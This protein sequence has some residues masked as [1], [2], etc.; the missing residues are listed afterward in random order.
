MCSLLHT[1]ATPHAR[2]QLAPALPDF[3]DTYD[4]DYRRYLS[5]LA[6]V[7][8]RRDEAAALAAPAAGGPRG[9]GGGDK[10]AARAVL[11]GLGGLLTDIKHLGRY[12]NDHLNRDLRVR[13][14]L[15]AVP[16]PVFCVWGGGGLWRMFGKAVQGVGQGS[17]GLLGDLAA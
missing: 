8:Q 1:H 15:K 10:E 6:L 13:W 7:E 17:S 9:G 5:L 12:Y 2:S 3:I 11:S 16:C 4:A 14:R